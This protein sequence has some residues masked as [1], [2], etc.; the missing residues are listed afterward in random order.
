MVNRRDPKR[1]ELI[2]VF[3]P[4][5]DAFGTRS[6]IA[7]DPAAGRKPSRSVGWLALAITAVLAA[8]VLA[9]PWSSSK[10]G[11]SPAPTA[12]TPT[13]V[14]TAPPSTNV[15]SV[16]T[17]SAGVIANSERFCSDD[18]VPFSA[19]VLPDGWDTI[20][21][22]WSGVDPFSGQVG[23]IRVA[24]GPGSFIADTATEP[25]TVLG[26]PAE[27][28]SDGNVRFT[29]GAASDPCDHWALIALPQ[30]SQATLRQVAEGLTTVDL[31]SQRL[32]C[33]RTSGVDLE[34]FPDY[35]TVFGAVAIPTAAALY[36]SRGL[37]SVGA[38]V[39][40]AKAPL[41]IAVNSSVT[42][43]VAPE[44]KGVLGLGW[45]STR[46]D[47]TTL[48]VISCRGSTRWLLVDGGFSASRTGCMAIIVNTGSGRQ[49]V[50]IGI[51]APCPGQAPPPQPP[52]T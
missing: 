38:S 9:S 28:G 27:L 17:T 47:Y 22:G 48:Q 3:E 11:R 41:I 7:A 4:G 10:K 24:H 2:E 50:P 43:S 45:Q 39:L 13:S 34:Q 40:F 35:Y 51:G 8:V 1:P 49:R 37:D 21:P 12:T 32:D 44:W 29:L 14:V 18:R 19:A 15:V 42:I 5:D 52:D 31:G 30:T 26:L 36:T 46:R 16:T 33:S 23:V 25:I 6:T 20:G